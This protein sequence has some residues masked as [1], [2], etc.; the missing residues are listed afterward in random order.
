MKTT[1]D[2][3]IVTSEEPAKKL[4]LSKVVYGLG[5]SARDS[6]VTFVAATAAILPFMYYG[7]GRNKII[8]KAAQIPEKIKHFSSEKL[9]GERAGKFGKALAVSAG[10]ATLIG[11]VAHVPG[12]FRGP[13]KIKEAEDAYNAEV[14]N[15]VRQGVE[16]KSLKETVA[17]QGMELTTA[18]EQVAAMSGP[19]ETPPIDGQPAPGFAAKFAPDA[20]LSKSEKVAA[21]RAAA[22]ENPYVQSA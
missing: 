22:G 14:E 1:E 15:S 20:G 8:D 16:I 18:K 2:T 9:G 12:L 19:P 10:L 11:Y 5:M 17:R 4:G 13:R 21:G 7:Q 3:N 6:L